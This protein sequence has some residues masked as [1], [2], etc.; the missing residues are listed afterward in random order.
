MWETWV[1]S[2]AWEDPLKKGKTTHSSILAGVTKSLTWLSS[3]PFHFRA[4]MTF[5][6]FSRGNMWVA[7]WLFSRWGVDHCPPSVGPNEWMGRHAIVLTTEGR[8]RVCTNHWIACLVPRSGCPWGDWGRHTLS[9]KC[10]AA[11]VLLTTH[12][13]PK[14]CGLPGICHRESGVCSEGLQ[15]QSLWGEACPLKSDEQRAVAWD[16][17]NSMPQ[18]SLAAWSPLAEGPH[19][20]ST[21]AACQLPD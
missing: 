20:F 15:L 17:D 4:I 16:G 19:C 18:T 6:K 3:F 12:W 2:L 11:A 9:V 5:T 10:I 14:L 21:W 13:T 7:L 1:L 8:A